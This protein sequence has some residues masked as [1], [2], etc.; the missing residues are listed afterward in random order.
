MS[1]LYRALWSDE[2]TLEH[3]E[4]I[5]R[6]RQRVA[7]WAQESSDPV[8]LVEGET[9]L[10]VSQGRHRSIVFRRLGAKAFDVIV[11]DQKLGDPRRWTV[12]VW[13]VA[14]DT[15]VHTLVEGRM[16]SDDPTLRVSVGRPRVVHELLEASEKPRLGKSAVLTAPVSISAE[17]IDALVETLSDPERSLPTIVCTERAGD[18]GGDWLA[19]AHK[20]AS[21]TEGVATVITLD[22][23]AVAALREKL[24]MLAVWGGGIRVYAPGPV[25]ESDG[26]RHRYYLGSRLEDGRY[27]TIDRIVYSVSQL[28]TRRRVPDVFRVLREPS[29]LPAN[30]LE[31]MIPAAELE[32]ER[33]RWEFDLDVA[34]DEHSEVERELAA[35][36]GHLARLKDELLAR[37]MADLLWGTQHEVEAS[38]PD[39]VQDTSEAALAAQLYLSRWLAL[40]GSAVRDVE[41]ID[42]SPN[43]FAWG[44]T[45]W[46]GLRALAAYAQDRLEGWDGGGFWEWCASGPVLGWP[47]TSKKLSMSEG[48]TV[49]NSAKLR[50]TRIFAV[51]ARVD[52]SGKIEMLAHL[53]I[54]EGGGPLAPRV[55][56]YDD[57]NGPTRMVH[58]GFVGPHALVPNK[59]TN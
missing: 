32:A 30:A 33:E 24:G 56:F 17:D 36:T 47:A 35:A 54:S 7:G 40:P 20:I 28:S 46:R 57:T 49:Q 45:T 10:D 26:W 27:P 55:Y 2:T 58:V 39:E 12:V 13:V 29:G 51:D 5:Q 59:S 43:A 37:G 14:D 19:A 34:R 1:L 18:Q 4:V 38:V 8:A 53:K 42:T 21:R 25:T 3:D 11:N 22:S 52:A 6:L 16:E 9:E 41:D 31:G 23:A 15:G 50:K 44:N 48:E